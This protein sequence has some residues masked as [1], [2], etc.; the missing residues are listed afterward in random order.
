MEEIREKHSI[1]TIY[2]IEFIGV[3]DCVKCT[4]T[5]TSIKKI[6]L[7]DSIIAKRCKYVASPITIRRKDAVVIMED[8][9]IYDTYI[10]ITTKELSDG[11]IIVKDKFLL[12]DK[13]LKVRYR[14]SADMYLDNNFIKDMILECHKIA[15]E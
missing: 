2:L 14:V 5:S 3:G 15:K 7:K 1:N 10:V 11:D 6:L 9:T 8:N 13:S 12:L 4:Y